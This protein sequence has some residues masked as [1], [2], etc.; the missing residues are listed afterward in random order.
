MKA[1]SAVDGALD[2]SMWWEMN[3][4]RY[5]N[6]KAKVRT[7]AAASANVDTV[8]GEGDSVALGLT[9]EQIRERVEPL[10]VLALKDQY[11]DARAGAAVALGKV[12]RPERAGAF[13]LLVR[14][15]N[16]KDRIV[17]EAACLGL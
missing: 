8:L 2:W 9:V 6:L 12:A 13:D 11:D 14:M 3:D 1:K 5:L 10:L 17:S 15:L 4:D 16:D 7:R